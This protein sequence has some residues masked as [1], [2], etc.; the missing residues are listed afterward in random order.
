MRN[1]IPIR[2]TISKEGIRQSS[3]IK[4]TALSIGGVSLHVLLLGIYFVVLARA[5]G[6]TD[7]GAFAATLTLSRIFGS[8]ASWG[9][10]NILI[11]NASREPARFREYWGLCLIIALCGGSFFTTLVLVI[12]K[13]VLQLSISGLSILMIASSDLIFAGIIALIQQAYLSFDRLPRYVQ[14]Q[15]GAS[16]FRLCGA[17]LMLFTIDKP[18]VSVWSILYFVTGLIPCIVGVG[19]VNKELGR[20]IFKWKISRAEFFEGFYFSVSQSSQGIYNDIDK[21]LLAS[22]TTLELAGLYT[23]A[24]RFIDFSYAPISGLL[25]SSYAN[26]FRRGV[27]GITGSLAWALRIIPWA[28]AYGL[29]AALG[30]YLISGFIPFLLGSVYDETVSIV[31]WLAPLIIFKSVE[32]LIANI[33][34]GAGYQGVRTAIQLGLAVLSFLATIWLISVIGWLGA[35]FASLGSSILAVL[36]FSVAVFILSRKQKEA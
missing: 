25:I 8:F 27:H 32:L 30:L 23:A 3:F 7:Y 31:R 12:S 13:L 10:G 11:K 6:P 1:I 4:N 17:I 16:A 19:L 28:T 34:T 29:L 2:I 21:T 9:Y 35:I 15:N 18:S 14:L 36:S 20:W 26:F 33:L 22:M 24:Y 5:L